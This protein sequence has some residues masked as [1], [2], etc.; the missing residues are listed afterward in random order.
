[1]KRIHS[2]VVCALAAAMAFA[3]SCASSEVDDGKDTDDDMQSQHA[4]GDGTCAAAEV[5]TCTQDCG[6]GSNMSTT[7]C[8]NG[9]CD[10]AAG[11]TQTSC[12][13][14]CGGGSGSGSGSSTL[15]DQIALACVVC[16]LE[17]TACIPPADEATCFAC[18]G[19]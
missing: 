14:D 18:A 5:G 1:M 15:C 19:L 2:G 7:A 12:P 17:P 3:F 11:E 10:A 16:L 6:N 9:A 8:G 13:Q 4:C